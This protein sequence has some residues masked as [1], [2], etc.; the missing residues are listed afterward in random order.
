MTTPNQDVQDS[1]STPVM[2]RKRSNIPSRDEEILSQS[3]T[4]DISNHC[5]KKCAAKGPQSEAIQCDMCYSWVNATRK[6]L[7]KEQYKQIAQLTHP[8]NYLN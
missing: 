6:D 8:V 5:N 2:K 7:K 1:A 3:K 4:I